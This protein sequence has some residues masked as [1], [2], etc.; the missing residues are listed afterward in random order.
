M[1]RAIRVVKAWHQL[2]SS[3]LQNDKTAKVSYL[4]ASPLDATAPKRFP[5]S[6]STQSMSG[7]SAARQ[8]SLIPNA[9]SFASL[10]QPALTIKTSQ[11]QKWLQPPDKQL[12]DIDSVSRLIANAP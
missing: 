7:K 3:P 9:E 2:R 10:R 8:T 5:P 1:P 6:Q 12:T 11:Y 4:T